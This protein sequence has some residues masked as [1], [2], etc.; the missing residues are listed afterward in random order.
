MKVETRILLR[1]LRN[2]LARPEIE[3]KML[4]A[5]MPN[6]AKLGDL[7]GKEVEV[8]LNSVFQGLTNKLSFKEMAKVLDENNDVVIIF[9][10]ELYNELDGYAPIVDKYGVPIKDR[11]KEVSDIADGLMHE[12]DFS[13]NE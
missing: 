2:F 5:V 4:T 7:A 12:G 1:A 10:E 6:D 8:P 3:N 9:L 13:E 11:E